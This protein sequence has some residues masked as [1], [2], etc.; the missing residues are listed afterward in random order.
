[1]TRKGGI[2]RVMAQEQAG[3]MALVVA[4]LAKKSMAMPMSKLRNCLR[5]SLRMVLMTVGGRRL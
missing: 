4:A 1:M 3:P 2:Q 5:D